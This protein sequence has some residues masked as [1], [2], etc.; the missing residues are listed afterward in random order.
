MTPYEIIVSCVAVTNL[1]FTLAVFQANRG[2]AASAKLQELGD[3]LRTAIAAHARESTD[4]VHAQ[5]VTLASLKA[6]ADKAP[7]HDDLAAMYAQMN[8]T[9]QQVDR[10]VG[11]L[12]QINS[13][14]RLLLASMVQK[15]HGGH[16][17]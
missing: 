17:A 4:R 10:L 12:D 7:N 8:A 11:E 1:A 2:K 5:D 13:N 14:L 15:A 3:E 6:T 16:G 9:R